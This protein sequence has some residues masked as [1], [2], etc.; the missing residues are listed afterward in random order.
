MSKLKTRHWLVHIH[1][2][3]KLAYL[4]LYAVFL[5]TVPLNAHSSLQVKQ[6][7]GKF[8]ITA[9]KIP[10]SQ[11]LQELA[12]Q[13]ALNPPVSN[14]TEADPVF[15][16]LFIGD[17][18]EASCAGGKAYIHYNANYTKKNSSIVGG[19]ANEPV[20]QQDNFLGKVSLP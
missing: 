1:Y 14:D 10:R 11:I 15:G 18:I 13:A 9:K 2:C 19:S 7:D 8:T 4:L 20:R 12:R 3:K 16:D 5:Y 17:Y 6:Q